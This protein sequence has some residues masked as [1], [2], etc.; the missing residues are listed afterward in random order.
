LKG[1]FV[2]LDRA[3]GSPPVREHHM[4]AGQFALIIAAVFTGAALVIS[5]AEQ[6]A[7]LELDDRALLAWWKPLYERAQAIQAPLAVAGFLLG[8]LAWSQTGNWRVAA[9][10]SAA[11]K[12]L[13]TS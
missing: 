10:T 13:R 12:E 8:L 11:K 9:K 1:F 4:L 2:T 7:R 6:P 5:V 3:M